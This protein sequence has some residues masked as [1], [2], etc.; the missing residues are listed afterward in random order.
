[1]SMRKTMVVIASLALFSTLLLAAC[2]SNAGTGNP[3]GS[4]GG[5]TSTP[6]SNGSSPSSSESKSAASEP[7]HIITANVGGKTPEEMKLFEK[8]L[9][10]LSGIDATFDRPASD[11]SKKV[12]AALSSGDNYDLIEESDL[13]TLAAFIQ[14]GIPT[15][16]TDFV[17]NSQVLSDP[18]VIPASEWDQL[19][20]PDGKIYGV[21]SKY[22]G[23]TMPIVRQDWLD[24]LH[25]PQPKT[26]DDYYQVLKAFKEQD[27]DGDGKAD[28]YGLSTAG[29]YDV[30]G[31]FTA[32]GVEYKYVVKNG[33]RTIPFATDAAVPI[34][35]WFAK[36]YKEGILDPNFVTN[37]TGKMRN[38][39]LTDR[40][41]MI[42]YWDACSTTCASSRILT[43]RSMRL[44]CRESPDLTANTTSGAATRTSGSF[45]PMPSTKQR[46]RSSWSSGTRSPASSWAASGLRATTI[47]WTRAASIS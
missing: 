41:G 12:A 5:S 40:V 36:L 22:Q 28:T 11:Y 8:E 26:L 9:K 44:G 33:K 29:M 15:D 3:S 46:L 10:K 43:P 45:R 6:S 30:Q 16:L 21:F 13:G 18:K 32:A 7:L 23:G 37:D 39:F 34:Y 25:L 17:K 42:T 35:E 24:K 47:P 38:L 19:K 20:G 31:F 14:Q 4:K 2:G 1:M 27:P